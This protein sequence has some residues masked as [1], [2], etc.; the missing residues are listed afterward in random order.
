MIKLIKWFFLGC[1][2]LF[3]FFVTLGFLVQTVVPKTTREKWERERFDREAKK[4]KEKEKKETERTG[5][6]ANLNSP[7]VIPT[8]VP[9]LGE[10]WTYAVKEDS[11]GRKSRLAQV[12]SSN[13]VEFDFPYQGVQNAALILRKHPQYGTEVILVLERAQ[14]L[15]SSIEDC[16]VNVRFDDGPIQRFSA[17]EPSDH[18][19]NKLFIHNAGTFISRLSKAKIVRM[20]P[21][22]YQAG[23]RVSEFNVEGFRAIGG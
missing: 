9:E 18:S 6:E 10:Q 17:G 16:I 2:G 21:E 15:C 20:E 23:R 14:F 13:S 11:M 3:T 7:V 1:L 5:E 4:A 19:T 22:F 8:P 12:K